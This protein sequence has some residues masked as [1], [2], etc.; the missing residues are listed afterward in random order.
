[1][2]NKIVNEYDNKINDETRYENKV[3][4]AIKNFE[5]WDGIVK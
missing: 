1:M 5:S 3:K 4:K 2:A